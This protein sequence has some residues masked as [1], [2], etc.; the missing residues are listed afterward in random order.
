M[1]TPSLT[2]EGKSIPLHSHWAPE[3]RF[4]YHRMEACYARVE[5]GNGSDIWTVSADS[6]QDQLEVLP[7][8]QVE[9]IESSPGKLSFRVTECDQSS[10]RHLAVLSGSARL[11]YVFIDPLN[12]QQAPTDA[13]DLDKWA[14]EGDPAQPACDKINN[15]LQS[16]AKGGGGT[17]YIGPGEYRIRTIHMQ[18]NTWLHLAEGAV[19]RAD[20]DLA[21]FPEDK[22]VSAIPDLAPS[23]RPGSRRCLI[24][25]KNVHNCGI[26]GK[27]IIDGCGSELR[28][29]HPDTRAM[30]NHI[31][32][33]DCSHISLHGIILLDS[34][35][36][37]THVIL[38]EDVEFGGVKIFNEIPPLG[39]DR[40]RRANSNS[41]WNNADGINPDSSRHI[42]ITHCFFHTGDDCVPIKN[43]SCYKGQ[44][45]D[46]EHINVKSCM[47]TTS[48]TAMK[49]GT[50]TLGD[51]MREIDFSDI[52]VVSASRVFAADM[53]DG[54]VASNL[55]FNDIRVHQCNRLFDFWI[56]R[57]EGATNQTRFSSIQNVR[58]EN[59][60]V[61][62]N[63]IEPTGA[64]SHITGL[65]DSHSVRDVS[66]TNIYVSRKPFTGGSDQAPLIINEFASGIKWLAGSEPSGPEV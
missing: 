4:P 48:T 46:V 11:L 64:E 39:W 13:V 50:E 33:I 45:A 55:R 51:N 43:T 60:R 24:Q 32:M 17:L 62:R 36:W 8:D 27:G 44:L 16:L 26:R 9:I 42:R 63:A 6:S 37:S 28:R 5:V 20:M 12:Y 53:K 34:E 23:L 2:I 40:F 61:T 52:E 30:C 35:F 7:K 58:M 49:I 22:L 21:N 59:V 66:F 25:F 19:L 38:S 56:L 14:A 41:T 29:L 54:A 31:R 18:S 65:S 10:P 1:S 47:M 57:R 3:P 15:A